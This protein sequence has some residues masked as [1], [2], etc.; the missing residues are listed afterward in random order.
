MPIIIYISYLKMDVR[1]IIPYIF[2]SFLVSATKN[3]EEVYFS[4]YMIIIIK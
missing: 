1:I 2:A 3:Y 4:I